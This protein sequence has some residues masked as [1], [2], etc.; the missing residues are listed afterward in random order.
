[1]AELKTISIHA[2]ILEYSGVSEKE[3]SYRLG[4]HFINRCVRDDK[5]PL[6][7]GLWEETDPEMASIQ[8][9]KVCDAWQW[10]LRNLPVERDWSV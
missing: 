6:L 8:I 3:P 1:M 7:A 9:L 2:L 5:D 10:D 4:Q